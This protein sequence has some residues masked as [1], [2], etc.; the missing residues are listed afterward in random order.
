MVILSKFG[1]SKSCH[2]GTR[3]G[4]AHEIYNSPEYPS[5]RGNR[6][7]DTYSSLIIHISG[8]VTYS[9]GNHN[10]K[11]DFLDIFT[12]TL[13]EPYSISWDRTSP[14]E[15]LAIYFD[16]NAFDNTFYPDEVAKDTYIEFINHKLH[17]SGIKLSDEH[18]EELSSIVQ[19][20][21]KLLGGYDLGTK[22]KVLS[23]TTHLFELMHRILHP[24][25]A[26]TVK[27]KPNDITAKAKEFIDENYTQISSALE[28][29]QHLYITPTYLSRKFTEKMGISPKAYLL[30]KKLHH[31]RNMIKCGASITEA[32]IESGFCNTSY[33][34]QLYKKKFGKTPNKS[35]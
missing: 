17:P 5:H 1:D 34:I 21:D 33:F 23:V 7:I 30:D 13:G 9:D 16:F 31:S 11:G 19:E 8:N 29:A 26:Q 3:I 22:Y 32:A 12:T 28:V 27:V 24:D 35:K 20:Y 2:I 4:V 18:K 15:R 14:Y 25:A 10:Y 6:I